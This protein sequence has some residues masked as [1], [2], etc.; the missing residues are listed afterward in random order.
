M[1]I[2]NIKDVFFDLD[3]TLW[4][5]DRNSKITFQFIFEELELQSIFDVFIKAYV[6]INLKYWRLYRTDQISKKE[7]RYHRLKE[8]FD[9]FNYSVSDD[10]INHIAQQY[11]NQ[12]SN[13]THLFPGAIELLQ[14]LQKDYRL[15]IITNG[16]DEVQ[17][18]KIENSG[19]SPFFTSVTTSED[20]NL[21]K[22]HPKVFLHALNKVNAKA[23]NSV[24]IGDNLEADIEGALQVGMHAIYFG[25][26]VYHGLK[27]NHLN[28]ITTFL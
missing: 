6:P 25:D 2:N 19:L 12:L 16:F 13:Q 17:Y 27:T 15:H 26:Q 5:F 24:M 10:L 20:V 23:E 3:H 28:K 4:D 9:S 21:K 22:P 18:K 14:V 11:I 8:T 1:K 7:L